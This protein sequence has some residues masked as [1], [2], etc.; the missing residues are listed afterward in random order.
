MQHLEKPLLQQSTSA[1]VRIVGSPSNEQNTQESSVNINDSDDASPKMSLDSRDPGKQAD[2][3]RDTSRPVS[4]RENVTS[5]AKD[6]HD[7]TFNITPEYND[8]CY[9]LSGT[10]L[11]DGCQSIRKNGNCHNS[12][13]SEQPASNYTTNEADS[14]KSCLSNSFRRRIHPSEYQTTYTSS[15]GQGLF[16]I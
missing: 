1:P 11:S 2:E 12:Y 3:E 6:N 13:L 7:S 10:T 9:K 5:T 8:K 15:S 14:E 4:S 16:D